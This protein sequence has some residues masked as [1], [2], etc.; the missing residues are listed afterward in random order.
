MLVRALVIAATVVACNKASDSPARESTEHSRVPAIPDA[1]LSQLGAA[2]LVVAVD[3]GHM[4]TKPLLAQIPDEAKC[5][6]EVLAATGV[7][8]LANAGDETVG[9]VT[10]VPQAAALACTKE[11]VSTLGV[12]VKPIAN[13]FELAIPDEPVTATWHD[14]TATI[15]ETGHA[16]P[17]G[18]PPPA[19]MAL[20]AKAPRDAKG[21]IAQHAAAPKHDIASLVGWIETHETTFVVTLTFEG[22]SA[23]AAHTTATGVVGGFK[24]GAAGKGLTLDDAWFAIRD[25]GLS[26]T[27]IAT[28]PYD[29]GRH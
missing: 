8:V 23:G 15:V 25:D 7:I 19:L 28:V 5:L 20:F 18:T 14:R 10:D 12:S 2:E 17:K 24:Q 21:V 26:S 29:L 4:N 1:I 22:T 3:L 13:G 27:V 6:R 16:P 9:Y 11:L